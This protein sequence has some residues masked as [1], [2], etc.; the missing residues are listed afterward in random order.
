MPCRQSYPHP[1]FSRPQTAQRKSEAR[2][3]FDLPHLFNVSEARIQAI[4]YSCVD[5]SSRKSRAK[6]AGPVPGPL[7]EIAIDA[8][9]KA[10]EETWSRQAIPELRQSFSSRFM[11]LYHSPD[12]RWYECILVE[13]RRR[14]TSSTSGRRPRARTF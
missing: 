6:C 4:R 14:S 11:P 10:R 3:Q 2:V 12:Q 13:R 5:I 1:V 8:P 9:L 7:L